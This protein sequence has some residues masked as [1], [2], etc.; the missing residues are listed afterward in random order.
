MLNHS[1]AYLRRT[2]IVVAVLIV[3]VLIG[4]QAYEYFF[5]G[6]C[7][8]SYCSPPILAGLDAFD[9]DRLTSRLKKRFPQGSPERSL[10]AALSRQGFVDASPDPIHREYNWQFLAHYRGFAFDEQASITWTITSGH[11]IA[12]LKGEMWPVAL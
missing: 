8:D 12:A 5:L 6:R 11:R 4:V 10:T 1:P 7:Q 2:G 9:S 3:F